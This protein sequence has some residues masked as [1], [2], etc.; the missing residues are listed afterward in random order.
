MV[1]LASD[2]AVFS[3]VHQCKPDAR[4]VVGDARLKLAAEPAGRFD[5]LV[6]DAFSS[7]AIPLHLMTREAFE[8]YARVIGPDGV[9]MIHVSNRFLDLQPVVAAIAKEL[10]LSAR[11]RLYKPTDAERLESYNPSIWIALARDDATMQR[12]TAAT[13]KPDA[14]MAMPPTNGKPAWSD[15]FA[16]V[17]PALKPMWKLF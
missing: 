12:F 10:G 15:D 4:M 14:W 6:V 11:V 7:D 16:S 8:T 13:G 9:V 5:L 2:P 3:Y 1:K 17:L